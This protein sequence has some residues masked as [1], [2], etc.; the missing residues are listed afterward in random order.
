MNCPEPFVNDGHILPPGFFISR[1][2]AQGY[3][4]QGPPNK[5]SSQTKTSIEFD[6]AWDIALYEL[7]NKYFSMKT[8]LSADI[9]LMGGI[10]NYTETFSYNGVKKM[11]GKNIEDS[12]DSTQVQNQVPVNLSVSEA[13]EASISLHDLYTVAAKEYMEESSPIQYKIVAFGH[14]HQATLEVYPK[15]SNFNS[16]YGNSGTWINDA[17]TGAYPSRTFLIIY[18]G[19][20]STSELDIVTYYQFNFNSTQGKYVPI[21]IK[22][23][24]IL[25]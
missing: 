1:L 14:T 8:D 17:C 21:R 4:T 11:F 3:M 15:G 13:L 20:W 10:D 9:I 22:E 16:I 24:N 12:W 6:L 2:Y 18:P 19:D 7:D 5:S 23:E 25:N